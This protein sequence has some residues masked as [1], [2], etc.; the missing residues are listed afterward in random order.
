MKRNF[1]YLLLVGLV[2]CIAGTASAQDVTV[3]LPDT[4]V[5]AGTSVSI[6]IYTE[7]LTAAMNVMLY[8][9]LV[10]YDPA[11]ATA[12]AP[13]T[14]GTITPVNWAPTWTITTPGEIL[15]GAWGFIGAM[16]GAGVVAYLNFDIDAAATGTC[17]LEF[18]EFGYCIPGG[19]PNAVP[20]DGSM[21]VAS[22]VPGEIEDLVISVDNEDLVLDW[23]LIASATS[24]NIYRSDMPYFTPTTVYQTEST[25][26]F[27]D[28]GALS[29]GPWFYIVTAA[30]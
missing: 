30:N 21:T 24:Y 17:D 8:Q 23:S 26:T 16:T 19:T 3:W 20:V 4:T 1:T 13:S 22:A 11:F 18:E 7:E 9:M 15:G 2:L 27:T 6:P 5:E 25:N 29:T 28:T 10:N 14:A 12:A